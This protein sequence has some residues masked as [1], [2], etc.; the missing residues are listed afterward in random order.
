[1]NSIKE[2]WI[3]MLL[4]IYENGH[5]HQKDDAEIKEIVNVHKY[6]E[7]PATNIL[8]TTLNIGVTPKDSAS[9]LEN[10]IAGNYDIEGYPIKGVALAE[11]VKSIHN[12]DKQ[13]FVYTYSNRLQAH[14][15]AENCD[16]IQ[17]INQIEVA[18][19]RLSENLGTNRAV[20][21]LYDPDVDS[22]EEDDQKKLVEDIPCLNWIQV[23]VRDNILN[24]HVQF[25]SNDAYNAFPSNMMLIT[26]LGM[27]ITEMLNEQYPDVKFGGIYYNATSV[28]Y[29]T[30]VVDDE[31]IKKIL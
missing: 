20:M 13:G 24:L 8:S 4:D 1:M 5:I 22:F 23:L 6:L 2:A 21:V 10:I 14:F 19:Q 7:D 25:R 18:L 11:Y 17:L 31:I 16:N 28:H 29:Y 9:Y 30:D 26:Y 27:R 12:K 3:D 15:V